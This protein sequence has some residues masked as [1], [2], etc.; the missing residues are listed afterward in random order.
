MK[1]EFTWPR[2][3]GSPHGDG[4]DGGMRTEEKERDR[5]N[6]NAIDH[7]DRLIQPHTTLAGGPNLWVTLD[8]FLGHAG[9]TEYKRLDEAN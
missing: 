5:A 4:K 3:A 2:P 1:M 6:V 8:T 9:H 7:F